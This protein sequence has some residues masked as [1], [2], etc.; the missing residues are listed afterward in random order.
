MNANL[1][2]MF[3]KQVTGKNN[4]KAQR[5]L[6]NDLVSS[7]KI[8]E[9]NS[10]IDINGKVG[11]EYTYKS[12]RTNIKIDLIDELILS[13]ECT[14]K[15]FENNAFWSENYACKH[16][17][18]TFYK[19]LSELDKLFYDNKHNIIEKRANNIFKE[20]K[21]K[22]SLLLQDD[23]NK[24]E[25][26]F[27]VHINRDVWNK[28]ISVEF[29]VGLKGPNNKLYILKDVNQ[30]LINYQSNVPT[31]YSKNFTFD[32]KNQKLSTED[33]RLIEFISFLKSI[34]S[35]SK[36]I[37]RS[38]DR[39]LD[40]KLLRIP[41][42]LVRN[43]F[44]IVKNHKVYLNESGFYRPIQT[45][46][47]FSEPNIDFDLTDVGDEYILEF[48]QTI[49]VALNF[50]KDVF[51]H[52]NKI[53]LPNYDFCYKFKSYLEVFNEDNSI[54][55]NNTEEKDILKRLIPEL[56]LISK[57]VTL[58]RNIQKKIINEPVKFNFY[59]DKEGKYVTLTLKVKYG[60][61]EF[62]IFNSEYEEKIIYRD[63]K[64]E[65]EVIEKLKRLCFEKANDKF[66]VVYGEQYVFTFFKNNLHKLQEIGEIYYSERFKGIK[67]IN[68]KSLSAN[69]TSKERNYFEMDFR[70]DDVSEEES[71][72]ILKAFR[73]NVK[74]F[75]LK[76]GEYIDLQ[77]I[78][79]KNFLKLL[80]VLAPNK[81]KNNKFEFNKNK[82]LFL[83]NFIEENKIRYIEGKKELKQ[84]TDKFKNIEKLKFKEPKELNGILREYQKV[85]FNW[86]KTLDYLGFGGILGDEMGLGKTLQ[87]ITFIL[88]NKKT[89]TLIVAPTS[90]LYNWKNE[91]EK[92]APTLNVTVNNGVKSE[93]EEVLNNLKNMDVI[94]TTYN[95]LKRD[96]EKYKEIDFDYCILDEAQNIK[97]ANSQNASSVK[98]IQAKGKFALTGT[99]IE[100]SI[101]ELWSI[102]DFIMPNY[103]YDG[104]TFNAKYAKNIDDNKEILENLNK[105][106]KPFILRRKKK[107][108]IKELPD[109]I[110]KKIEVYLNDKQRKVYGVY[111]NHAIELIKKKVEN[112]EF[113]RSK[114]EIL[115]HIMK[116]R[117]LCLD[118]SILVNDYKGESSK[119]DALVEIV[120]NS[121][122]QNHRILVFSQFTQVLKKINDRFNEK[123]IDT[124]YL[125]GSTPSNKRMEIV[126]NFNNGKSSVFL[127][128]LKAGGT[129]LNLTS[130]DVV[131]HFDPWWNPAVEEQA[132]DRAHRIGQKKVVQVIKLIAKGTIEEKIVELQAEK[133][134]LISKLIDNDDFSKSEN[135]TSLKE[136]DILR[137]FEN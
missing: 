102:F 77:E 37:Y 55:F 98:K 86:F 30:F 3:T 64:R 56:K 73:D 103:L 133:K 126:K 9:E 19:S 63:L 122:E 75:K 12:Y 43:F 109:K 48:K 34:E 25:V 41:K 27:E 62:N 128:S 40:G 108:V 78:E 134:A 90:L 38:S 67:I 113:K 15:D 81:I 100:N 105:L 14:C 54:S 107:E 120:S 58:S 135:L 45:E 129:G 112:D 71:L 39:N 50:N 8:K 99:P 60:E 4:T 83:S 36:S 79:L 21:S 24:D 61:C 32:S 91:F 74:Y 95:L 131:I 87:T 20:E 80:D 117:Q 1:L 28:K 5:I 76:T 68:S 70:I 118:P 136:D 101:M 127:I 94:I 35:S 104:K 16:V 33:K 111:A 130:A 125:D 29:K 57:N 82:G 69:V 53:Y 132:T 17:F 65:Q 119:I 114:L 115:A 92:F 96:L 31:K 2:S 49:P 13:T 106:I 121:I 22:L 123:G 6:K 47:L 72:N 97:N 124:S 7:V 59:F 93:R 10:I 89:K 116:L 18:A 110:E 11:S 26:Q 44:E 84:I 42:E 51:L 66:N 85:G 52:G 46:I 88:S 23:E 137:L